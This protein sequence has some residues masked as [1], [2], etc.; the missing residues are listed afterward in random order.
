MYEKGWNSPNE[1][2]LL[3]FIMVLNAVI[4]T[5][6]IPAHVMSVIHEDSKQ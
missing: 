5:D 4:V 2:S 1:T 6:S 3:M